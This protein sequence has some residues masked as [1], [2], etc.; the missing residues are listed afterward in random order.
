MKVSAGKD[1]ELMECEGDGTVVE[2]GETKNQAEMTYLSTVL[3]TD[4]CW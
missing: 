4:R 3:Q 2:L 1:T